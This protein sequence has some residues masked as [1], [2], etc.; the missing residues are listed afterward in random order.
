MVLLAEANGT[1]TTCQKLSAA[2]CIPEQYAS[3]VLS[4]LRRAGMAKGQRGRYGGF[5]IGCDPKEVTLLDIV[6]VIDPLQRIT[7]CLMDPEAHEASLSALNSQIDHSIAAFEAG[8][9]QMT[10]KELVD[11][12][13]RP[14][15]YNEQSTQS[16]SISQTSA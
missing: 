5:V 2:G 8:L 16:D 9:S 6:N 4:Q 12:G 3:K 13:S 11:Q 14:P 7:G 10:I 15:L 1:P